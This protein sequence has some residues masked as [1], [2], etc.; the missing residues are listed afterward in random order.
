MWTGAG[1]V[2]LSRR[3]G[4]PSLREALGPGLGDNGPL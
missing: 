4:P 1:A 2:A 3:P